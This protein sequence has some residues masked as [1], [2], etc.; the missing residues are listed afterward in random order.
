MSS[1]FVSLGPDAKIDVN[2]EPWDSVSGQYRVLHD[3]VDSTTTEDNSKTNKLG[4]QRWFE[5]SFTAQRASDVDYH[6]GLT[7]LTAQDGISLAVWPNGRA[8]PDGPYTIDTFLCNSFSSSFNVGGSAA[9][10]ASFEG[11]SS[12]DF[13]CPGE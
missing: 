13:V 7:D 4:P 5:G 1:D 10:E 3:K 12:G 2:G 8:D 11:V 6:A 9:Q